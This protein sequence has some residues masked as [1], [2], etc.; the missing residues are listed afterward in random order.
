MPIDNHTNL[1]HRLIIDCQYQSISLYR[2]VSIDIDRHR[3]SIPS[4]GYTGQ[5]A[6]QQWQMK[7]LSSCRRGVTC[8]QLFAQL[9]TRTIANK[10][11][12]IS[13]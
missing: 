2:L 9:A 5:L 11:A 1:C 13:R 10:M 6:T 4:I 12:E 8:L 7:N 3:L